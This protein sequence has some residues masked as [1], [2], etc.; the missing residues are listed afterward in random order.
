METWEILILII[1][2]IIKGW[3]RISCNRW[4]DPYAKQTNKKKKTKQTKQKNK[5]KKNKQTNKKTTHHPESTWRLDKGIHMK[6]KHWRKQ[7]T[8]N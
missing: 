3:L 1:R 6:I 5:K 7:P 8:E 4:N 2:A